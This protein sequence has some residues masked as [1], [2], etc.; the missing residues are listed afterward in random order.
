MG[1][2]FGAGRVGPLFEVQIGVEDSVFFFV[3]FG[4][5]ISIGSMYGI[6]SY[7]NG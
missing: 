4:G 2:E 7:M 3:F 5:I 1:G 6:F